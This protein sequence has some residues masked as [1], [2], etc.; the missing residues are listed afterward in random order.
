MHYNALL[1]KEGLTVV[2]HAKG[3]NFE[4]VPSLLRSDQ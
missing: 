1:N 3:W 4:G 2:S